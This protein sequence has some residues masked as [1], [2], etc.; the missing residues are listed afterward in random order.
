MP[1]W[2]YWSVVNERL[3]VGGFLVGLAP[4]ADILPGELR[5]D[6]NECRGNGGSSLERSD[7]W[8]ASCMLA[9]E[10]AR[11]IQGDRPGVEG[12]SEVVLRMP[13]CERRRPR[14]VCCGKGISY[15]CKR[16]QLT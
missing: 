11:V 2:L 15:S 9:C 3:T 8:R 6:D 10:R 4:E 12:E 7:V 14:A 16:D 5:I 13:V 1:G